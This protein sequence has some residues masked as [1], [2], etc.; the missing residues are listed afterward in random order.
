M[1]VFVRLPLTGYLR[2]R[3]VFVPCNTEDACPV[4]SSGALSNAQHGYQLVPFF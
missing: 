4:A 1:K 3:H 2:A